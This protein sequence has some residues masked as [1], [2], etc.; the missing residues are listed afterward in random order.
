MKLLQVALI[1]S[2]CI[3]LTGCYVKVSSSPDAAAPAAN[4]TVISKTEKGFTTVTTGPDP[5]NYK[6]KTLS[7]GRQVKIISMGIIQFAPGGDPPALH[8]RYQTDLSMLD[9]PELREEADAIW[10]DFRIEAEK[11]GYTGALISA[12]PSPTNDKV[13]QGSSYNFTW[14]KDGQGTWKAG[15]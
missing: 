13:K 15:K 11:G 9:I 4:K 12:F 6:L 5:S 8:L 3:A 10:E 2:L 14:K 7:S 1:L